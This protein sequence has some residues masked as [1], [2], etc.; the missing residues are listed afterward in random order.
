MS[1]HHCQN[2]VYFIP[3]WTSFGS[4][5][6]AFKCA[7]VKIEWREHHCRL[8]F[9]MCQDTSVK[10]VSTLYQFEPV[11]SGQNWNELVVARSEKRLNFGYNTGNSFNISLELWWALAS[12]LICHKLARDVTL[13]VKEQIFGRASARASLTGAYWGQCIASL[14]DSRWR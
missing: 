2:C 13:I 14:E 10:I 6:V 12:A 7:Q 11:W 8:P 4:T 5:N 9:S 1:G 3:I